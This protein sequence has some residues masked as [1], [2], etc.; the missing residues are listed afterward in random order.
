MS[1]T[2]RV[3]TSKFNAMVREIARKASVPEEEVLS[4]EV[5]RILEATIKHTPSAT[6]ASIRG[7]SENANFSMQPETL[8]APKRGRAGVKITKGGFIAYYLHN[9]YP[10]ALWS[11]MSARRKVSLA[12]KLRA[13]GLARKSWLDIAR[14]L[15]LRINFP[16]YVS[17]AVASTGREYPQNVSVRLRRQQGKLQIGFTNAQPTVNKIGGSRALQRAIDGRYK[18]FM[19]QMGLGTFDELAKIAKKYPGIRIG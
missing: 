17:S 15:G 11:Q 12:A 19:R 13:R 3:D 5:A 16:G 18:Y 10:D 4:N 9:R 6:V 7:T 1:G 14:K 2:V 8:Y